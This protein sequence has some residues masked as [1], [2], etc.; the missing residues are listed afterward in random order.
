MRRILCLGLILT[1]WCWTAASGEAERVLYY[2]QD[3]KTYAN[4]GYASAPKEN[5]QTG[6]VNTGPGGAGGRRAVLPVGQNLPGSRL[7]T[8]T[9]IFKPVFVGEEIVLEAKVRVKK[10]GARAQLFYV[11]DGDLAEGRDK[12]L[13][14]IDEQGTLRVKTQS[15]APLGKSVVPGQRGP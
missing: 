5:P 13:M 4:T 9:W 7:M 1:L 2:V 3:F 8:A 11:R 14:Y 15:A 10:S 6:Q 12:E